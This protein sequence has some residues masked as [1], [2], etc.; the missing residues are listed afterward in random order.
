ME[1][2]YLRCNRAIYANPF[3]E[4]AMRQTV[5]L[6]KDV[7]YGQRAGHVNERKTAG[8]SWTSFKENSNIGLLHANL[9][10][11]IQP[12]SFKRCP[13]VQSIVSC[14]KIKFS[15]LSVHMRRLF[16]KSFLFH[17]L[18]YYYAFQFLNGKAAVWAENIIKFHNIG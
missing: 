2:S 13:C 8:S 6:S 5:V 4:R 7:P 12:D 3:F 18:C 14:E 15:V 1:Y 11:G 17:L 10:E 9:A 16:R